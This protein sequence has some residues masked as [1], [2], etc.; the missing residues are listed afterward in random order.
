M[1]F[2]KPFRIFAFSLLGTITLIVVTSAVLSF[3]YEK[4]VI[5][6]MKKYLDE[7]LLT[8]LSMKDIR[9]RVLKGFPNATVEISNVVLLSGE[10]FN[11]RDFSG[12]FSDTLLQAKTISFQFDLLKLFHK[13]YELK[14]IEISQGRLNIL[15]DKNN[16]HNLK[17]WKSLEHQAGQDYSVNLKGILLNAVQIK[18]VSLREQLALT[19]YSQRTSFR[20]AYSGYILS[21]ETRGSLK[22][23]SIV[24][25]DKCLIK[26]ASLHLA[27]KMIYGGNR[28]RISQ[29]RI[30]LNKAIANIAGEY[31]S[32]KEN[33][34][35]LTIGIPKFGLAELMSLMPIDWNML[36]AHLSFTGNGK[37]TAVIRGSLSNK[38]NLFIRSGF[39][40]TRCSARNTD[41]RA[42][43]SNINLKGSISGTRAENFE[44]LLDQVTSDL[45]KGT[46]NGSFS[47]QNLRT[48]LFRA[49]VHSIL[50]LA[51]FKEFAGIDTVDSMNGLIR[52]DFNASGSLKQLTDST[53]KGI[54][55]LENGIFVFEK[56]GIR[57]KNQPWDIQNIAGKAVWDKTLRLNSLSLQVN[58]TDLL[59]N[60]SLQNLTGY[61]LKRGPLNLN[62]EIIIDNFDIS[63][64]L[65]KAPK[66]KSGGVTS[67]MTVLLKDIQ[68]KA[69]IEA[70]SFVAGKFKA[71]DVSLNLTSAKD[72]AYVS[73][74][75]L[76]FPD[77]TITGNALL[78][79]NSSNMLSITCN[80]R[81]QMINIQQLFTAFNNFTQHFIVDKNVKGQLSG[82]VS[83]FAQWDST[84]KFIPKSLKAQAD[85][86]ITNGELVQF[87][88]MLRL[89]K[90]INVDELRH[91]RFKTLKNM[92]YINDRMVTL[93]EMAI[94]STA[95]NIAVSGQHSFDNEFDYRMKVLLSEVLYNKAR[96]KKQEINEFLV[97]ETRADQ[98]TI[99][100]IIAGTPDHFDVRF[101]R[102]RA[103]NLT[104]NN[105][106]DA[107]P[108][109][110]NR[111]APDNFRIVWDD[112]DKQQDPVTK[113]EQ[114]NK[115]VTN[116]SDSD[117][118]IEWNEE[119]SS[120][121]E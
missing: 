76:K 6:Y 8:E 107:E 19:A 47:L 18:I 41:T 22:L 100:L 25:Q 89:S 86:E 83:F 45:G 10:D 4:A 117:F 38:N 13:Q 84:L 34:I 63:S 44:L 49:E 70:K 106:K 62:L 39:E 26:D 21:G 109:L 9:F 104:R 1:R 20:G 108:S 113:Q 40:L 5:R 74:F 101:D 96:K 68:L 116:H 14:K 3:F 71:T 73:N 72:S 31:K 111:P 91:I 29:G 17:I 37:L 78:T 92:I 2:S 75:Y 51:A 120:D 28:F 48:L 119:D 42:V 79:G 112:Q 85:I 103:F 32:G 105:M 43:I 64:L 60:G 97:D 7:H 99:P 27:V 24:I 69:H 121:T 16:R 82:T 66:K 67:G 50:D 115:P 57:L 53:V 54:D 81:P 80:S 65:S 58:G 93:P 52:S 35:D 59:V 30:H 98:T 114:V 61:L 102:K 118:T 12:A 94:H 77:G 90:Y 56:A 33:S 15:L 110:E 88:P 55:F 95:F 11:S 36:P 23:N 46:I 87:E